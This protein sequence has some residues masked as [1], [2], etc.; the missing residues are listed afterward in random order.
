MNTFLARRA[1]LMTKKMFLN[2]DIH[3]YVIIHFL[4][5]LYINVALYVTWT[6]INIAAFHNFFVLPVFF[7]FFFLSTNYGF[8]M[9]KYIDFNVNTDK[10]YSLSI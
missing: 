6:F 1:S 10:P 9:T 4:S 3:V 2:V 8:T 5:I 7:D